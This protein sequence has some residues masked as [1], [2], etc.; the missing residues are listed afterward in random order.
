[1][2][3]AAP[4]LN[5]L[6][7]RL[8]IEELV[9]NGVGMFCVSPGSRST[10][11]TWAVADHPAAQST[12]HFDERGAAFFALG[13]ARATGRPAALIC[14][15]GTAAANYFPAIIEASMDG[16]PLVVL[17]ADRPP[18]D[19]RTGANQTIDQ[20]NLYGDYPRYFAQ[21]PVPSQEVAAPALLTL[22]DQACRHATGA[23]GGPVHLN[24][25]FRQ[26]LAPVETHTDFGAYLAPLERWLESKTPWTRYESSEPASAPSAECLEQL[27]QA[28]RGLLVV[29][30]LRT[31]EETVAAR[32]IARKLGWPV[33]ADVLSGLRLGAE[34]YPL[35]SHF[36]FLLLSDVA[37]QRLDPD[38]ILH[39]GAPLT[40]K[41]FLQYL[42]ERSGPYVQVVPHHRGADP[43][44]RA[45][46][47][48][49][50]SVAALREAVAGGTSEEAAPW[51]MLVAKLNNAAETAIGESVPQWGEAMEIPVYQQIS[52]LIPAGSGLF[53]GN[54][55]PIRDMDAFARAEGA[56][57][58]VCGNRGASG[59][60]GCLAT[61][62][63]F[64]AAIDAPMTAIVGD[65]TCL[66][67]LNSLALVARTTRP[68]AL[69]VI[70]ND[71]GGI[72][73]M[74]PVAQFAEHF[75]SHFGTPHG[76]TLAHAAALFGLRYA[77]AE[78]V[79]D[80]GTFYNEATHVGPP[81]LIE[82]R[83]DRH[84]NA[85]LHARVQNAVRWAVE[86]A[87]TA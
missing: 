75:E 35:V 7:A 36:D 8:L 47:R 24:C 71:G 30:R 49:E 82:V 70:N 21:V 54:S 84:F 58:R 9:R 1:M 53:I 87:C 60:D 19:H 81:M 26:P 67:D 63:G 39:I 69:V 40:S 38:L 20:V 57:V 27:R 37:R 2:I 56:A 59:I 64:A 13:W 31:E 18:E 62:A 50:C 4:N 32:A 45:T 61:A 22:V 6:W 23:H 83:T 66:H 43:A 41:R 68:F 29:G 86:E 34:G 10:P 5:H 33:V 46:G 15:S 80:I 42:D 48:L 76:L 52:R 16:V 55:M 3:A 12:V 72:F 79:E 44:H 74:L 25:P 73:S 51:R 17:T 11:L 78:T 77:A 14:T 65:L 85:E 28:R